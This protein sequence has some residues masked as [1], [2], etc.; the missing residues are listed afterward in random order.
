MLDLDYRTLIEERLSELLQIDDPTLRSS[1][2]YS[3]IAPSKRIRPMMLL[4]IAGEAGL[5]AACAIEMIHTYS[6]IHDDL[7]AMDDDDMRRGKLSLHV[8]TDEATAILTGDFLLTYAFEL[9]A[10]FPDILSSVA[11]KIGANGIIGGQIKDLAAKNHPISFD[12]YNII[13]KQKTGALFSAA[14]EAGAIIASL[15]NDEIL[16]YEQFGQ[17]FGIIFQIKDDLKDKIELS[18]IQAIVGENKAKKF[19]ENLILEAKEI[20]SCLNNPPEYLKNLLK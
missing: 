8:K 7:P 11:K 20:L 5:D 9:L 19:Q 15:T 6:L 4:S 16:L 2:L 10:S 14:C 18:S 1:A 17:L 3:T 13:A 12:E